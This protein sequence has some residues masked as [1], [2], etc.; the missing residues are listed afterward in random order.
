MLAKEQGFAVATVTY[1][2]GL[3][4][5]ENGKLLADALEDR[6]MPDDI[7]IVAHSMGSLIARA[8]IHPRRRSKAAL[9]EKVR[10]VVTLGT[11]HAGSPVERA[12]VISSKRSAGRSRGAAR[13]SRTSRRSGAQA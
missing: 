11:P 3:P 9:G 2:S 12:P 7:A 8:A 5:I 13:R 1:N 6:S 4:V 10:A